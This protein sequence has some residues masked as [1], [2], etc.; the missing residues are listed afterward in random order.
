M[1]FHSQGHRV[2]YTNPKEKLRTTYGKTEHL[3]RNTKTNK[4]WRN[5]KHLNGK[6]AT[7]QKLRNTR[8]NYIRKASIIFQKFPRPGHETKRTLKTT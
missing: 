8:D 1:N 7:K 4:L 2:N 5:K 3:S 6:Q